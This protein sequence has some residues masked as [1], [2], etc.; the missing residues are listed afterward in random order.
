MNLFI[1]QTK[2]TILRLFIRNKR[3][4][5]ISLL[6]PILSY[7]LF[8]KVMNVGLSGAELTTWK[9]NYLVSMMT[10]GILMDSV[11]MI[12]ST[13][14]SDRENGFDQLITLSPLP[15]IRYYLSVI[16]SFFGLFELSIISLLIVGYYIN[17]VTYSWLEVL[18]F[19]I[20]LPLTALPLI[21]IGIL[22]SLAGSSNTV[23]GFANLLV[24]PLAIVSGLW[25]PIS[26]LP[27]W[28]QSIGKWMPTYFMSNVMRTLY[29]E[30]A[31]NITNTLGLLGWMIVLGIGLIS[32]LYIKQKKGYLLT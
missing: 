17:G 15:K 32:V 25:W 30:H 14:V 23:S 2:I 24:F 16:V 28:I 18:A 20:A 12:S 8:T 10:Y 4:L 22:L 26:I 11:M 7:L 21:L 3:F 31:V 19:L 13:L 29:H 6:I 27:T 9:A 5:L 1:F